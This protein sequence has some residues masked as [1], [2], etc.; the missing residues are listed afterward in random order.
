MLEVIGPPGMF[1]L[2]VCLEVSK[3]LRKRFPRLC[4]QEVTAR[5]TLDEI[6]RSFANKLNWGR[7]RN[8]AAFAAKARNQK[9]LFI[10]ES[11]DMLCARLLGK[12]DPE[13]YV[14]EIIRWL[15]EFA[16]E[17]QSPLIIC[18][19]VRVVDL[20]RLI[21]LTVDGSA[22]APELVKFSQYGL[23]DEEW[24]AWSAQQLDAL[25]MPISNRNAL[26][27]AAAYNPGA[28]QSGIEASIHA[29][30]VASGLRAI[31]NFYQTNSDAVY[32]LIPYSHRQAFI[33]AVSDESPKPRIRC[34]NY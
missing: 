26:K 18:G 33:Q 7:F 16:K 3:S 25:E 12:R 10:I 30:D 8:F 11:L 24:D 13:L 6:W 4:R 34:T 2:Q 32:G 17:L 21:N 1:H 14:E 23:S 9:C 5:S 19:K 31:E 29:K 27:D 22:H 20:V 28:L 15:N